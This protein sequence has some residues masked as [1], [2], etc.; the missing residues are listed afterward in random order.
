MEICRNNDI[1]KI[2]W[3]NILSQPV[4]LII[5]MLFNIFFEWFMTT[6]IFYKDENSAIIKGD[7]LKDKRIPDNHIDLIVTSPPYNINK[8]YG[9]A[10]D[11]LE[12]DEYLRFTYKWL[13]KCY[14]WAKPDGRLCMNIPL[15]TGK[16]G[17]KSIGADIISV[18][19][20]VG[21]SYRTTIIWN[22][23]NISKR[24][25]RGS[26]MSASSPN[27]ITPVELIVVMYKKQWKKSRKGKSDITKKEFIEWTNGIWTFS[28]ESKKKIGHPAPFPVELP[29]RCIK[30]FSYMG[31][32]VL[33][34][35]MGS[36]TT[37]VASKQLKRKSLGIEVSGEYCELAF[38][39]ILKY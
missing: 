25:A 22:E 19:K 18:A 2:G 33:D 17:Q 21:W 15:D 20:N 35:F 32:I 31:D 1:L 28:G 37:L 24:G 11:N 16:G 27:V 34:P 13:S 9:E 14:D 4:K 30:L 5:N 26:F 8:S 38:R 7:M 39:R 6:R 23:G 29:K 36:G 10:N 3:F 12:Y